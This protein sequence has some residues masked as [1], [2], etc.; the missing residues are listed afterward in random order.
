MYLL[1][2]QLDEVIK[3]DS[4]EGKLAEGTLLLE[5]SSVDISLWKSK[6]PPR[7]H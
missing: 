7:I 2:G 6:N 3:I 5:F 1:S 4:T